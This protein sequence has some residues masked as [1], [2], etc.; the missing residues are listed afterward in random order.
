MPPFNPDDEVGRNKAIRWRTLLADFLLPVIN[1][2]NITRQR[3]IL[4]YKAGQRVREIFRQ[5]VPEPGTYDD[6]AKARRILTVRFEPQKNR[7]YEVYKINY[8]TI[9]AAEL[10][11][12]ALQQTLHGIKNLKNIAGNMHNSPWQHS[13]RP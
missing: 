5:F 9:G 4:L 2:T 6:E 13:G 11:Q 3:A 1:I 8:G 7:L 10:F 12:H